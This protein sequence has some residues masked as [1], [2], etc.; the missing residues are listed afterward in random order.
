MK[1]KTFWV[2]RLVD[3]RGMIILHL[4]HHNSLILSPS[5][6]ADPHTHTITIFQLSSNHSM[7][8]PRC[9]KVTKE[10]RCSWILKDLTR[11]LLSTIFATVFIK[12]SSLA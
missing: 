5:L 2:I 12:S 10:A 8:F 11:L 9:K 4:H 6:S 3:I 7:C 1:H